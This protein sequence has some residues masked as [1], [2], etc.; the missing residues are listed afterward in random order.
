MKVKKQQNL[1][2]ERYI[3]ETIAL[4]HEK[5]GSRNVNLREVS[6]RVG[7]AHTNAYNYFDGFEGL[8][9]AAFERALKIYAET[10]K[11]GLG[12]ELT[13]HQYFTKL[14]DNLIR[15]ATHNPGL[16]R[17]INTDPLDLSTIPDSSLKILSKMKNYVVDVIYLLAQEK[18]SHTEALNVTDILFAYLDGET[19]AIINQR[20]FPDEDVLSRVAGNVELLF[21]RLTATNCDGIDLKKYANQPGILAFPELII[22]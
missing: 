13:G 11:T 16:F 14:I 1:T 15:F 21:T 19:L 10:I 4:I 7:C 17:F 6:K 20:H 3:D 5:G 9:W 12:N 8:L 2:T 22:E 18:L